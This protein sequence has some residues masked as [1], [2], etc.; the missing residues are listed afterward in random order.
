MFFMFLW[1][2]M[3]LIDDCLWTETTNQLETNQLLI[4]IQKTSPMFY[5]T[6]LLDMDNMNGP[7]AMKAVKAAFSKSVSWISI[8]RNSVRQPM[9]GASG[10]LL[11][12]GFLKWGEPT[13][14]PRKPPEFSKSR[15]V[16]PNESWVSSQK[17]MFDVQY[18]YTYTYVYVWIAFKFKS[19]KKN[20]SVRNL[21]CPTNWGLNP[22]LIP[23][24]MVPY[25]CDF[26]P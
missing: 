6:L 25:W 23:C 21:S 14:G 11:G 12:G 26:I 10:R 22:I 1:D 20:P 8:E 16:C 15:K 19:T 4:C 2:R 17:H 9:C 18:K 3:M 5:I 13:Q 7:D 24:S